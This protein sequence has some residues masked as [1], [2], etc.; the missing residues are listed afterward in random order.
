MLRNKKEVI[1]HSAAIYI[2]NNIT[3]LQRRAWN[4]LLAYAYDELRTKDQHDIKVKDLMRVLEFDSKNED[5]LKEALEALV[6]CKLKWNILGKDVEEWGVTTLLSEALIRNGTCLYGYGHTLRERLHNPRMYARI[7]LSMQNKFTS[8][9]AQALWEMCVDC[10]DESR[11]YGETRF[12]PLSQYRELMGVSGGLYPE[13]KDLSKYVIKAP[14]T[15]INEVTDFR[16]EADYQREKR[17]VVAVKFKVRRI[18]MLPGQVAA[19]QGT[20]FPDLTDMPLAVRE[21]KAAGLAADEAWKIWQEGFDYV[22]EDKRP[23]HL[24]DNPETAFDN[25]VREKTHLLKRR[26]AEQKVKNATGFLREAIRMNYANPEYTA[27]EQWGKARE[28][29]KTRMVSQQKQQKLANRKTELQR[30]RND[31]VHERCMAIAK[32]DP[33]F[34]GEVLE[35]VLRE[36]STLNQY[37]YPEKTLLESYK[38]RV[39]LWANVDPYLV[40]HY[41]E[42]FEDIEASHAARLAEIEQELMALEPEAA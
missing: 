24:G 29:A 20:L 33:V 38:D 22:N 25:Y 36:N 5:Y 18:Q 42:R 1:K 34:F 2:E 8:K 41:P 26:Q 6:T 13:F 15:E 21:M 14:V 16:V 37:L 3:L 28:K 9:H 17:K 32:D 7:S 10:L 39:M 27:E 23:A 40:K 31:A 30:S 19:K 12:I 4:V 11:N 35:I